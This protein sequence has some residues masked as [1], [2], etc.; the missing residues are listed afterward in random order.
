M[1]KFRAGPGPGPAKKSVMP[2]VLSDT[3]LLVVNQCSAPP[4]PRQAIPERDPDRNL[5]RPAKR[6]RAEIIGCPDGAASHTKLQIKLQVAKS[7]ARDDPSK[8][9]VL[10][11]TEDVLREIDSDG[12]VMAAFNS[13]SGFL[14]QL[15]AGRMK[16][17]IASLT[18]QPGRT[19]IKLDH[20]R[21]SDMVYEI[22]CRSSTGAR[23]VDKMLV[24]GIERSSLSMRNDYDSKIYTG[25]QAASF[26]IV[27]RDLYDI[28]NGYAIMGPSY[29]W[30][31]QYVHDIIP[32]TFQRLFYDSS[33]LGLEDDGTKVGDVLHFQV[34]SDP[35][36]NMPVERPLL[37]LSGFSPTED[38][39]DDIILAGEHKNIPVRTSM[40]ISFTFDQLPS[41]LHEAV[42][43]GDNPSLAACHGFVSGIADTDDG[44][45][46]TVRIALTRDNLPSFLKWPRLPQESV[47]QTNL[48]AIIPAKCVVSTFKIVPVQLHCLAGFT[49]RDKHA[50][51]MIPSQPIKR[52]VYVAGHL[53]LSPGAFQQDRKSGP[54]A[55][56]VSER[57]A[58]KDWHDRYSSDSYKA[59]ALLSDFCA[60]GG[61]ISDR[62]FAEHHAPWKVRY[63]ELTRLRNGGRYAPKV[64]LART[65]PFPA[66]AALTTIRKCAHLVGYPQYGPY[67]FELHAAVRRCAEAK[68]R[69]AK[70]RPGLAV[71][72]ST[73]LPGAVLMQLVHENA[74][75]ARVS[76]KEGAVE[77]VVDVFESAKHLI[78]SDNCDNLNTDRGVFNL[79]GL[80]IIEFFAPITFRWV[81]YNP[82]KCAEDSDIGVDGRAEIIFSRY[83]AKDR[84]G[85]DLAGEINAEDRGDGG[86]ERGKR[87]PGQTAT[88]DPRQTSVM[89]M[90]QRRG[91]DGPRY[92]LSSH[93]Y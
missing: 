57:L 44:I 56:S 25:V 22:V 75:E 64:T 17:L 14:D 74:K 55:Q 1:P 45:V 79:E 40:G 48:M 38:S 15:P 31:H 12:N 83:V 11:S 76:F 89:V 4:P 80:G 65:T 5:K 18:G 46:L 71:L 88:R 53:Q 82:K 92:H 72:V 51:G 49:R 78:E 81:L 54:E 39:E 21:N 68:A 69:K 90:G 27:A 24:E 30:D 73:N 50:L 7:A 34:P 87:N 47:L 91:V 62:D 20:I 23:K 60:R 33:L 42:S 35:A 63:L 41:S 10:Q 3:A 61:A 93:Y 9:I 58:L 59:F 70:Y 28:G 19:C 52:D 13:E 84:H 77:A 43:G 6:V 85:A 26:T 37:I 66:S 36:G 67:M 2:V 29:P 16:E 8:Y 32:A 86:E